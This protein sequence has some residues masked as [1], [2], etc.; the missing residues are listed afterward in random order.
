MAWECALRWPRAQNTNKRSGTTMRTNKSPSNR[1]APSPAPGTAQRIAPG[2]AQGA[3]PRTAHRSISSSCANARRAHSEGHFCKRLTSTRM[4]ARARTLSGFE[5]MSGEIQPQQR[6]I[7]SHHLNHSHC[8]HHNE[9]INQPMNPPTS[10]Q[11]VSMFAKAR[12][13]R[14]KPRQPNSL[15]RQPQWRTLSLGYKKSQSVI[16]CGQYE[17]YP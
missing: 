2:T 1:P 14:R 17:E 9:P 10:T 15:R 3:A 12:R 6:R 7:T 13:A 11:F 5:L 4:S 8:A 16:Q